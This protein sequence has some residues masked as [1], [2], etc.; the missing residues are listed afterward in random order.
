MQPNLQTAGIPCELHFTANPTKIQFCIIKIIVVSEAKHLELYLD[1][2]YEKTTKGCMLTMKKGK[3]V[4]F[5]LY[6]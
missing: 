1:D 5:F 4:E 3:Y 6:I 2:L